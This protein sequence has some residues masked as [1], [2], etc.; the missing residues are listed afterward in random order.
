MRDVQLVA[1]RNA[2]FNVTAITSRTPEIARE[3]A[4]LRG[5]PKV[6]DTLD[7][8]LED[9]SIDILDIAVPPDCQLAIIQKIT[10][11]KHLPKGILAQKPLA[12]NY[13]DAQIAVDLCR[14]SGIRLAV[15][16][17]MRYDQSIRALRTLL[18]RNYLGEPVLATI[19]MRAVHI[20][21]VA[22]RLRP[23]D[24]TQYERAPP[25]LLPPSVR[26]AECRLCERAQRS[27]HE[28]CSSGWNLSLHSG[29]R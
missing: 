25:G 19:E 17:N 2:G 15:N 10:S 7:K 29:V 13:R 24:V 26:R 1:Y 18:R 12:T 3:V 21:K 28:V 16:Q 6:Y 8:L 27:A 14:A 4:D 11:G 9:E 5:I 23:V 20:G 22:S